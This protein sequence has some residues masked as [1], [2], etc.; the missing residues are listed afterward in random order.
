MSQTLMGANW[1]ASRENFRLIWNFCQFCNLTRLDLGYL[2]SGVNGE[3]NSTTWK[4][5]FPWFSWN[6][7]SKINLGVAIGIH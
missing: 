5:E 4:G 6:S 7:Y 1:F 3:N 2:R